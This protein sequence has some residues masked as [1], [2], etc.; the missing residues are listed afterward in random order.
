MTELGEGQHLSRLI[1]VY[2]VEGPVQV[3]MLPGG[4]QFRV[5]GTKR[6]VFAPWTAVVN[7]CGTG[8]DVPS[9][10]MNKPMDLLKHSAAKVVA[11]K[12][13]NATKESQ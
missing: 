11:T 12:V 4:I 7:A 2:G 3:T 6:I 10:L 1:K 8:T 9:F 5:K 13:K